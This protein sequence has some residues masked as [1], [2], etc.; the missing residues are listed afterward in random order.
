MPTSQ[1]RDFP[2]SLQVS[3]GRYIQTTAV[4][5]LATVSQFSKYQIALSAPSLMPD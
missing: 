2:P 4:A 3:F 1:L 5:S